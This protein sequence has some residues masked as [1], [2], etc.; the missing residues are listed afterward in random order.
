[1][2]S[3]S[4]STRSPAQWPEDV[5]A[6]TALFFERT[7]AAWRCGACGTEFTIDSVFASSRDTVDCPLCDH[8]AEHVDRMADHPVRN[9]GDRR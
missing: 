6:D 5:D 4:S 9:G 2:S 1:M 8:G 3:T 7:I